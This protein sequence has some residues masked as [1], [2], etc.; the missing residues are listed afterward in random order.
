[1]NNKIDDRE[2]RVLDF[3]NARNKEINT[4]NQNDKLF[5]SPEMKMR[6]LKKECDDGKSVFIDTVFAKLY[7]DTLPFN[8][9]KKNC[10]E[11]DLRDEIHDFISNRTNGR[12]SEY[13]V[14]EAIKKNNSSILKALLT[15]AE[16]S[17]KKFFKETSKDIGR[18][19]VSD[20]NYNKNIDNEDIDKI[21]KKM[22]LDE[23]AEIIQNNVQKAIEDET[24]KVKREDKFNQQIED[25]LTDNMDV[26]DDAS[27]ESVMQKM[28][29]VKQPTVYQPSLFEAI[30]IGNTKHVNESASMDDVF[31]ETVEEYTK[32]NIVKALKLESFNL[33]SIKKLANSYIS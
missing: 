25:M 17:T 6:R 30:M 2:S 4:A 32:L 3:I 15:E 14:R 18:I 11:D 10:S 33:D 9:P 7:K 26:Q 22:E 12:N 23:I 8:D 21:T 24:N 5:N 20:L 16:N 13:Y 27:M 28:N 29:I 31:N 19:N 1:M